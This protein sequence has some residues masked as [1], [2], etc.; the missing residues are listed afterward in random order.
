MAFV[1]GCERHDEIRAKLE[2]AERI[3]DS[4]PDS[5]LAVLDS[6]TLSYPTLDSDRDRALY[7]M[8]YTQTLDKNHLDPKNDSLISFAVDYY[9]RKKDIPR[10]IISTYYRGRVLYHREQFPQAL[11]SLYK[12]KELAEND[13]SFFWAGMAC[14]GIA[15]I[16]N[17]TYNSA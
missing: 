14:R 17:D 16:Y 3:M 13:S 6:L 5:A 2:L 9:D 11:V 8:L 1:G 7:G 4:R 12:A 10:Q 15:D